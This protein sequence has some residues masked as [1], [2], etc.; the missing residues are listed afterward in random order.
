MKLGKQKAK[1]GPSN[2]YLVFIAALSFTCATF[3]CNCTFLWSTLAW[4]NS[5]C[6]KLSSLASVLASTS[7]RFTSIRCNLPI[8]LRKRRHLCNYHVVTAACAIPEGVTNLCGTARTTF[9]SDRG[10]HCKYCCFAWRGCAF[11]VLTNYGI[12]T[13]LL[14][15]MLLL[16]AFANF[17]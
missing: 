2:T 15:H 9:L 10:R 3:A 1:L 5:P 7:D 8:R 13:V 14:M 17:F 4:A 16:L 6:P 12:F 11:N